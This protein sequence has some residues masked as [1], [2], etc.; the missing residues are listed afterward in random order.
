MKSRDILKKVIAWRLISILVTML[1]L[2]V[3][4]GDIK[5]ATGI[6]VF[7]HAVLISCHYVFEKLWATRMKDETR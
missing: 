3:A 7:L 1:V 6:T 2:F 4:T 5:S